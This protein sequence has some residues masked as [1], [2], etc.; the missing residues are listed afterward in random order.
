LIP[1]GAIQ[2]VSAQ[3]TILKTAHRGLEVGAFR[4]QPEIDWDCQ[5]RSSAENGYSDE[6]FCATLLYY[7][8]AEVILF[9]SS[10]PLLTHKQLACTNHRESIELFVSYSTRTGHA[11]WTW[12]YSIF[13]CFTV[14]LDCCNELELNAT[15]HFTYYR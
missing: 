11:V 13:C 7:S 2:T 6:A 4:H 9:S 14:L 8:R 10:L 5:N 1:A 3:T 12:T 15:S